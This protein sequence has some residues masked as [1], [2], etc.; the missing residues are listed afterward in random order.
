MH[1]F[2]GD[3]LLLQDPQLLLVHQSL[4]RREGGGRRSG[5]RKHVIDDVEHAGK[6]S[7]KDLS[8]VVWKLSSNSLFY[9]ARRRG[10]LSDARAR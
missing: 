10:W 8:V 5:R 6:F 9:T 4:R 2:V 1:S 7:N 3:E